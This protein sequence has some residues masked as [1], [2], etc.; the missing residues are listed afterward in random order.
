MISVKKSLSFFISILVT[1]IFIYALSNTMSLFFNLNNQNTRTILI[2]LILTL[3]LMFFITFQ[4]SLNKRWNKKLLL[5]EKVLLSANIDKFTLSEK[6]WIYLLVFLIYFTPLIRDLSFKNVPLINIFM[7]FPSIVIF[8]L[9]LRVSKNSLKTYFTER[10]II[11][12]G[13]D[14]RLYIPL[15][16]PIDN[17]EGYYP[18]NAI[19]SYIFYPDKIQIFIQ[20][21]QGK[22][23]LK[24]DKNTINKII[25]ILKKNGIE[26]RKIS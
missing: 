20:Y 18:Y 25:S 21:E 17:L 24:E 7:F 10:G 9:L 8:E 12:A 6:L 5:K 3:G 4:G 19:D 23:V 16:K 15:G 2:N 22:L 26:T 1:I 11:V 14:L 13:L